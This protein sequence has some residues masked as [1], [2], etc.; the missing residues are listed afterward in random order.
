MPLG[1]KAI[2]ECTVI[3]PNVT[4]PLPSAD[5]FIP[6]ELHSEPKNMKAPIFQFWLIVELLDLF[7]NSINYEVV[8]VITLVLINWR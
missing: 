2:L 7:N 5:L 6:W 8:V 4:L 3:T 1:E